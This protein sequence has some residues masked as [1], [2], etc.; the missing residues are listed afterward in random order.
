MDACHNG[1]IGLKGGFLLFAGDFKKGKLLSGNRRTRI[2][3][4][5]QLFQAQTVEI[6]HN[7]SRGQVP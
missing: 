2:A 5:D 6:Q 4:G 7:A 1:L 3:G